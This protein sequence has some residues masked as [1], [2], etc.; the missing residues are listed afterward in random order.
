M[1]NFC[2][3]ETP[4]CS[5][6]RHSSRLINQLQSQ[7]HLPRGV[8]VSSVKKVVRNAVL[9]WKVIDS[10]ALFV[11]TKYAELLWNPSCG[12]NTGRLLGFRRLKDSPT[13][14][15]FRRSPA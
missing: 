14:S 6:L 5:T 7:L 3:E 13:N 8:S 12:M 1:C 9:G 4:F 15:I 11:W 2:A 10:N